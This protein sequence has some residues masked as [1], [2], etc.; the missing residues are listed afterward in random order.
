VR[1]AG[2]VLCAA[3][4]VWG[5][6]LGGFHAGVEWGFWPGPD[7][8]SGGGG[9]LSFEQLA[10]INETRI[11]PCDKPQIRIFWLSFAGWN[12]LISLALAGLLIRGAF[13]LRAERLV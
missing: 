9:A 3:I 7:T 2:V 4:F 10:D 11:V 6:W 12:A 8:C 13:R 1:L 5:T